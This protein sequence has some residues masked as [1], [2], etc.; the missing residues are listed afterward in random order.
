VTYDPDGIVDV[1]STQSR[2]T[3][4]SRSTHSP[5]RLPR[6][7]VVAS[8]TPAI[9]PFPEI[10]SAKMTNIPSGHWLYLLPPAQSYRVYLA[11]NLDEVLRLIQVE[12]TR[13]P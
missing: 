12:Q 2:S 6:L 10:Q 5:V 9:V 13:S 3:P 4:M 11:R 8:F 7:R 1:P